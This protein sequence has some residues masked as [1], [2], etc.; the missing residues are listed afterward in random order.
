MPWTT[1]HLRVTTPLFNAG[2][3]QDAGVRVASLRGAMRFWFRALAGT[4]A[5]P[6]LKLL[7]QMEEAVFGS[8][9]RPSPVSMRIRA[10]P[11]V[12]G[13]DPTPKFIA[14]PPRAGGRRPPGGIQHPRDDGK[15]LVYLLG[16]GLADANRNLHRDFISA[17]K[18]VSIDFRFSGNEAT[19]ALALASLWLLCTYGGLGSR[20]RRGWGGL[21]ITGSEGQQLPGDWTPETILTPG[22]NYFERHDRLWPAEQMTMWQ[23]YLTDLPDVDVPAPD[24]EEAWTSRPAYPVLSR[25]WTR[26]ALWPGRPEP[27]WTRVLGYAGEQ[28]RWFRAREDTPGVDYKPM[29][30]TPEW[31]VVTDRD[32]DDHFG[33][34]ALGLPIVF[35]KTGPTV[36]ADQQ[37]ASGKPV[38]LRRASPLWLRAVG[39]DKQWKLFSFAFQGEFL[40]GDVQ[41]HVWPDN[42]KPVRELTVTST[43]VEERTNEWLAA[44][45]HGRDLIR[46]REL[47]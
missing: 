40:P 36:H 10:Q 41:V 19:D 42:R 27:D 14:E 46:N 6:D 4:V 32:D 22:L 8:T 43:D 15:W 5:G 23:Y 18:L 21:A 1:V 37:T 9:E 38:P 13:K 33:L 24:R 39:R 16:Q 26:A 34:G 25:Q 45:R 44:V 47:R 31:R 20:V 11:K 2:G 3:A 12:T 17:D 7:A 35:K 30:K 28:F 29:V